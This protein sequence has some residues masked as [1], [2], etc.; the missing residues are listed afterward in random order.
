MST[1]DESRLQARLQPLS[2]GHQRET[3][4]LTS[5]WGFVASL[6][7]FWTLSLWQCFQFI[8]TKAVLAASNLLVFP[9][10]S[11]A[12]L[13]PKSTTKASSPALDEDHP[14]EGLLVVI[15]CLPTI[16]P[17]PRYC[18]SRWFIPPHYW[19]WKWNVFLTFRYRTPCGNAVKGGPHHPA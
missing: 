5:S 3:Y 14:V 7:K 12:G 18:K 10:S 4:A 2:A 8:W 13:P 6:D 11:S 17:I 1:V 19:S 9:R 16:P 15:P